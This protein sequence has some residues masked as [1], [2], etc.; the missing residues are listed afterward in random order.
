VEV[1][2]SKPNH[3]G[4]KKEFD[5][6]GSRWIGKKGLIILDD[7]S[8]INAKITDNSKY[9]LEVVDLEN[10]KAVYVHKV[11]IKKIIIEE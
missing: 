10:N 9:Y 11:H 8:T 3:G 6:F 5:D 1:K 2:G 4:I 7:N